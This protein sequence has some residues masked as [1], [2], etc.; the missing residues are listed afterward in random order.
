MGVLFDPFD[1]DAIT[2]VTAIVRTFEPILAVLPTGCRTGICRV[3]EALSGRIW[4]LG[5]TSV[6]FAALTVRVGTQADR[7]Q[8]RRSTQM[9]R[10]Q[11]LAGAA[12]AAAL[13][14]SVPTAATAGPP[15]DADPNCFGKGASQMARGQFDGIDGMGDHASTQTSPRRGIGNTARDFGF[16]HQSDMAAF[17]GAEC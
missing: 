12:L 8:E 6:A 10:S 11:F 4:I 9:R 15:E 2:T 7:N 17:L 1:S 5:G 14:I 3:R 16:V 13:A